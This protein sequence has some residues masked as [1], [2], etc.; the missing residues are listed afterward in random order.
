MKTETTIS[1]NDL[2]KISSTPETR[3]LAQLAAAGN[4]AAVAKLQTKIN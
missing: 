3:K 2:K 1:I 4:A